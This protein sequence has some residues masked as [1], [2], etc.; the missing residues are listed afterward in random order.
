[1]GLR[2]LGGPKSRVLYHHIWKCGGAAL[3]D[4]ALRSGESAPNA[5]ALNPSERC[6]AAAFNPS[7]WIASNYSFVAW[8]APLPPGVPVGDRH[9]QFASVVVLRNPLDQAVSH[10]RHAQLNYGLWPSFGAFVEYGLCV[11]SR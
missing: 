3:C 10:F 4:A 6:G 11:A 1:M 9:S 5:H 2:P 7:D 8:Q